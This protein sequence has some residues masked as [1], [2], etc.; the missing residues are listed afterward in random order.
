MQARLQR[1][2][3][4]LEAAAGFLGAEAFQVAQNHRRAVDGRQ[5]V[6]RLG[7]PL[8]QLLPQQFLVGQCRPVSRI[9]RPQAARQLFVRGANGNLG[10]LGHPGR[11]RVAQPRHGRVEGD[12]VN[13]RGECRIAPEE[14]DLLVDLHQHVLRDFLGVFT[15]LHIPESQLINLRGVAVG[16]FG[17]RRIVSGTEAFDKHGVRG[18]FAHGMW[19]FAVVVSRR[20][21][22]PPPDYSRG[23]LAREKNRKRCPVNHLPR[24]PA[25]GRRPSPRP[26]PPHCRPA[27]PASG[28]RRATTTR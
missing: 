24:R 4:E 15:V 11:T 7:K 27:G 23:S 25:R 17:Q 18:V 3:L 20:E 13:P 10:D 26:G 5:R 28:P 1:L 21:P 9:E 8:T 16:Q 14:V 6:D 19:S 12:A 2:V 22:H